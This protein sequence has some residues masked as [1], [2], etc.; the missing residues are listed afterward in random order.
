MVRNCR[1]ELNVYLSAFATSAKRSTADG[2]DVQ[3]SY[4]YWL[5]ESPRKTVCYRENYKRNYDKRHCAHPLALLNLG[6][7]VWI[8]DLKREEWLVKS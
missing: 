2:S 5:V 6:S 3:T 8:S 7:N 4:K 1:N